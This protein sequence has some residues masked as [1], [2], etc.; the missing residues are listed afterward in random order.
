MKRNKTAFA[1]LMVGLTVF[2][3]VAE[4]LR[5]SE[6]ELLTE[7]AVQESADAAYDLRVIFPVM[8]LK[9]EPA[10]QNFTY[11]ARGWRLGVSVDDPSREA[12]IIAEPGA[13]VN[14]VFQPDAGAEA[15]TVLPATQGEGTVDW[16]P[17]SVVKA[18]YLPSWL[19]NH[20]LPIWKTWKTTTTK[21]GIRRNSI[22]SITR[23]R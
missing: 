21:C 23:R 16:K 13:F 6:V 12:V 18:V 10:L 9:G 2:S 11:S 3:A 14:G 8:Q 19:E 1:M 20:P 15:V 5:E 22:T 17:S 7:V 4:G